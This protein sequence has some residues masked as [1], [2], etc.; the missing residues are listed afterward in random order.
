MPK[1]LIIY[2]SKSGHTKK[3]A[4]AI[5]EGITETKMNVMV[6]DVGT[7]SVDD[8]VGAD[9]V[10]LGSPCYYGSMAAQMK[11]FIDASVKYHGKLQGKVGGAFASS[12]IIGGGNESTVLGLLQA[13]LIHGMVVAG[14]AKISHYGPISIGKPDKRVI[15]ECITYGKRIAELTLKLAG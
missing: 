13:L 14:N 4:E 3:M 10:I 15:D 11:A 6:C 12:G 2:H 1:A 7:A 5:A 8:L 9:A